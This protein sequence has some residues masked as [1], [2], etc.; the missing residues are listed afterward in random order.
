MNIQQAF[1]KRNDGGG[2]HKTKENRRSESMK[3]DERIRQHNAQCTL[4]R[5][6]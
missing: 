5:T 4:D 1:V 2:P 6:K 3:V